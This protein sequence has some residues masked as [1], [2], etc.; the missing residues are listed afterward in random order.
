[1]S[2]K[3]MQTYEDLARALGFRFD[4][5]GGALYGKCGIYDVLI[6]PQ[7]S[8]YPYMLSVA[9]SAQR[10]AGPL[11][12]EDC[13]NFK[14]ENKPVASLTQNGTTIIM[15]L[16]NCPKLPKLQDNLTNALNALVSLLHT[17]GFQNCCQSCGANNTIPCFVSGG[18]MHLCPD[19]Y[20]KV[21]HNSTLAYSQ[22]Q[23]KRESAIAGTVGALLGSLLGV[24]SIIIFSQLGYVSV[25]SG[26]IMAICTLKGY[27]MLGGKLTKKG[28]IIC[29]L[30]MLVMTY[31][32]D[33]LDWAIVIAREL[34]VELTLA[35]QVLPDL[36]ANE[37]I[38][39]GT[40]AGNLVLQYLFVLIGAVP[41]IINTTKNSKVKDRIY[42]LGDVDVSS[43]Y[44]TL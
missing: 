4:P 1:M 34:E 6:Y 17:E 30:M 42:R 43:D 39:M 29:V 44:N 21:Q 28:I 20:A 10:P 35:Y 26:I 19:C 9:V 31:F 22:K 33:R 3:I 14:R 36:L 8:S 27:E 12:K 16:K 15:N 41:T 2:N 5:E 23:G 13:K 7:N 40:Y 25:F 32:G 18:Y 38:D 24:L 37:I 11:A